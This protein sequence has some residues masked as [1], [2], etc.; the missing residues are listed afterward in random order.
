MAIRLERR[1][2][3]LNRC[4]DE[5]DVRTAVPAGNGKSIGRVPNSGTLL[6]SPRLEG[7]PESSTSSRNGPPRASKGRRRATMGKSAERTR[8]CACLSEDPFA[9]WASVRRAS[10]RHPLLDESHFSLIVLRCGHC[11]RWFLKVFAELIDW[12]KGEDSQ[13][14]VVCPLSDAEARRILRDAASVNQ[15]YVESLRLSRPMLWYIAPRGYQPTLQW[16]DGPLVILPH[17]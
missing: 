1:N 8:F 9:A 13:C 2:D 3:D 4:R 5:S 16:Q 6:E 7:P 11:R 10:E 17:D 15:R 14:W 12:S